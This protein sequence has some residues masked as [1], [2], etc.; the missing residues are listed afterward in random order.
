MLHVQL[1]MAF[2]HVKLHVKLNDT[3]VKLNNGIHVTRTTF[4]KNMQAFM[5]HVQLKGAIC[6]T[7]LLVLT[8]IVSNKYL[9]LL[10]D[11]SK[12]IRVSSRKT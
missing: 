11:W 3:H 9:I 4:K 5:L 10:G 7:F 12:V 6:L 2:K 1:K 8:E